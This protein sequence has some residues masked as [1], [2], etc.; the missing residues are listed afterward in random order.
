MSIPCIPSCDTVFGVLGCD[1]LEGKPAQL[2]GTNGIFDTFYTISYTLFDAVPLLIN[3][4]GTVV[5]DELTKLF[6]RVAI[7]QALPYLVVFIVMFIVL[8]RSNVISTAIGIML[9]MFIIVMTIIGVAFILFYTEDVVENI[10]TQVMA[11]IN[12]NFINN[13]PAIQSALFQAWIDPSSAQC[14]G[15]I[16][17]VA[18]SCANRKTTATELLENIDPANLAQRRHDNS[19]KFSDFPTVNNDRKLTMENL[20]KEI[21][22]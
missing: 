12:T 8:M 7:V 20:L 19:V 14:P 6:Y 11:T 9:I 5:Q 10:S 15:G 17:G 18:S 2:T 3:G 21:K 13:G 4:V 16:A 1:V 22:N